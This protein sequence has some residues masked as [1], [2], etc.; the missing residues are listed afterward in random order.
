MD[1]NKAEPTCSKTNFPFTKWSFFVHSAT[2]IEPYVHPSLNSILELCRTFPIV[3]KS[4]MTS[5]LWDE[6][7]FHVRSP[8][9]YKMN[10]PEKMLANSV[11][12]RTK[13]ATNISAKAKFRIK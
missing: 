2:R 1:F 11:I 13:I 7:Q 3:V 4:V 9:F 10:S 5:C 6:Y 12:G 8:N